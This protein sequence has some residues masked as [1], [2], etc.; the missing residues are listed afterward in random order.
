MIGRE[1]EIKELEYLYSLNEAQLVAIYGRRRVGK[2]YLINDTF[3][4]RLTFSHSGLS[5]IEGKNTLKDQL[6]SFYI[7]L[8]K[9][10]AKVSKK[11]KS[12]LEAFY[13]LE[14]FLIEVDDGSRQVVFLDELPWLDTPRSGFITAFESFWN[15]WACSRHNLMVIVCGSASSWILDNLINNHGG[16]YN[17]VTSVIKL[18]PFTLNECEEFLNNRGISL[19]RYDIA[20]SYMIFGGIPYYLGYFRPGLSLAKIVDNLL[21]NKTSA[22]DDEFDR[23]FNSIFS[24]PEIMKKIIHTLN[25]NICGMTKAELCK[26]A[27][28]SDGG[29]LNNNLRAL[30]ASDF[31]QKYRP[32]GK[33]VNY[34][35]LIDPFC[36]FYLHFIYDK[37]LEENYWEKNL[38]SQKIITWRGFAFERLCFNHIVQIKQALQ[39]GGISSSSSAWLKED[40]DKGTQID[41]IIDRKDNVVNMCEIKYYSD[42]FTVTKD[43]YRTLLHRQ[44][45]LQQQISNKQIVHPIAITTYGLTQNEYS[46]FFTNVITLNDLFTKI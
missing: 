21:F 28:L 25:S 38:S 6:D 22:L 17:R 30:I 5:P 40:T 18:E 46:S 16:L 12:W 26:K 31:I 13:Y 29:R 23:L 3:S 27:K 37:K 7:S 1:K 44:T 32:F 8:L 35:K 20:Q 39:I 14:Q 45:L 33:K 34:Y 9:A 42:S 36:I 11:P 24:N 10:G 19:S 4:D 2:T 43:Y 41:L 15:G